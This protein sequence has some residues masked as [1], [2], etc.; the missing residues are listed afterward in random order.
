[1]RRCTRSCALHRPRTSSESR[2]T[3]SEPRGASALDRE[4]SR[5]KGTETAFLADST[6]SGLSLAPSK[7]L[8]RD[9][10]SSRNGSGGL[11]EASLC[12]GRTP[13][14]SSSR[15]SNSPLQRFRQAT[16]SR[17]RRRASPK[18]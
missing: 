5:D 7:Q 4:L 11:V 13:L 3:K 18:T 14:E 2:S 15:A 17:E 1:M 8:Q 9:V 10:E 16:A 12:L 6:S